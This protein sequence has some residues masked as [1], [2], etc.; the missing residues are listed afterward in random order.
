MH[1]LTWEDVRAI[2]SRIAAGEMQ[3]TLCAEF[4]ISAPQMSGIAHGKFWQEA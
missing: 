3:K 2:R 4:G 1:R